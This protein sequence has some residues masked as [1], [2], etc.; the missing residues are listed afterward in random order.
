MNENYRVKPYQLLAHEALLRN[1]KQKYRQNDTILG[2]YKKFLA[3][4]KGE[5]NVDYKL[6]L[7]PHQD[8]IIIKDLR[9]KNFS[10]NFQIDTLLLTKYFLLIIETK[11]IKGELRYD[12]KQHQFI[13]IY[14]GVEK[15]YQDPILQAD[16]QRQ[17]LEYWLQTY[18]I[19]IPI[20][21]L[22]V[23]SNPQTII[24]NIYH[25]PDIYNKLIR[26]ES[27]HIYLSKIKN[28]YKKIYLNQKRI[29][30]LH[31]LMLSKNEPYKPNLIDTYQLTDQYL[32]KG[33]PCTEC[34]KPMTKVYRNWMCHYCTLSDTEAYKQKIFD[35]FLLGN[36]TITNKECRQLLQID[37]PRIA[38]YILNA[39]KLSHQGN[40]KG[41]VYLAP[42]LKEYP[43]DS[44]VPIKS[45]AII[46]N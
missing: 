5:I 29:D 35:Y 25:D 34:Y 6:S 33:V 22:I 12:S 16:M 41:R 31:Q 32:I 23:S 28:T 44:M 21:T 4:Y 7:Y 9:L 15:A 43:Q 26:A 2:N 19:K 42:V 39:M 3:G 24:T 1:L 27:L 20:E 14:N 13:Q 40:N 10:K 18:N 17:N 11:N 45:H 8:H 38:N 37:S 36:D 46:N 30:E